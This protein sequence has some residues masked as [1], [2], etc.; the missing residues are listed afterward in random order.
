MTYAGIVAPDQPAHPRK[1]TL[2]L[3]PL[4][5]RI[6]F[7]YL[8]ADREALRSDCRDAQSDTG[9]HCPY[10]AYESLSSE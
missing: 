3:C 10:I 6:V 4:I 7:V 1:L 9:Q 5:Y 8:S 2:E